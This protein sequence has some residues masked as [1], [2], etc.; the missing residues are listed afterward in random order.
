MKGK[1]IV[2]QDTSYEVE[3]EVDTPELFSG[4]DLFKTGADTIRF[5]E[6]IEI[7]LNNARCLNNR[8]TK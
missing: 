8:V 5:E 2:D 6:L 4:Y 1:K 3:L 7:F